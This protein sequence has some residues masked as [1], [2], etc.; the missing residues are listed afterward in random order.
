MFLIRFGEDEGQKRSSTCILCHNV[1]TCKTEIAPTDPSVRWT[2][3]RQSPDIR[4][5]AKEVEL[6]LLRTGSLA[7]AKSAFFNPFDVL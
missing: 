5:A 2:M 3:P 1:T 6:W 4:S 7:A